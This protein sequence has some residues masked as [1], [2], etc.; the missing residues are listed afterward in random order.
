MV[1]PLL[2]A[3][4][5]P[6]ASPVRAAPRQFAAMHFCVANKPHVACACFV[7]GAVVPWNLYGLK[8]AET[9][10][11]LKPIVF[12]DDDLWSLVAFSLANE[13]AWRRIRSRSLDSQTDN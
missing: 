7:P 4:S 5:V 10:S 9:Q 13:I 8:I 6:V 3:L 1:T 12:F 2:P 11:A